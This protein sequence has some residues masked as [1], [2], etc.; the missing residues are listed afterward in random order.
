[1]TVYT[2]TTLYCDPESK[3]FQAISIYAPSLFPLMT[4]NIKM[5]EMTFAGFL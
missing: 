2:I 4:R 5:D 3:F 1:M